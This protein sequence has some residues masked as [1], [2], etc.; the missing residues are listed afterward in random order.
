M[1]DVLEGENI[2]KGNEKQYVKTKDGKIHEVLV[3]SNIDRHDYDRTEMDNFFC[4]N[5]LASCVA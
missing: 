4:V 5:I 2:D 3:D 1:V